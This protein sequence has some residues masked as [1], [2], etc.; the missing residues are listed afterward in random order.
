MTRLSN[1]VTT[2]DIGLAIRDH[3]EGREVYVYDE[4]VPLYRRAIEYVDA[5]DPDNLVIGLDS[6]Q[7]FLV[8]IVRAP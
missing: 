8:R 6:A 5:S 2:R 3:I 7:R 4:E 1:G